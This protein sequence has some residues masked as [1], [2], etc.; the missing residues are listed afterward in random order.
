MKLINKNASNELKQCLLL[1]EENDF[2]ELIVKLE[3]LDNEGSEITY[4]DPKTSTK[5]ILKLISK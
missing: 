2:K 3:N 1:L 5:L 4:E